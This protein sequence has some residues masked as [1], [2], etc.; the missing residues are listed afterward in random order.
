M[1]TI[2][3]EDPLNRSPP[4]PTVGG[5]FS[6]AGRNFR[7]LPRNFRT[8]RSDPDALGTLWTWSGYL[9]RIFPGGRK[10]RPKDRNFRPSEKLHKE[11]NENVHIFEGKVR[12]DQDLHFHQS[13]S[14]LSEGNPVELDLGDLFVL[15]FLVL[16]CSYSLIPP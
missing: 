15:F 3:E 11:Q 1:G 16:P 2:G 7:H 6:C 14:P 9:G 8:P 5:S 10:F 12:G 4:N 13:I